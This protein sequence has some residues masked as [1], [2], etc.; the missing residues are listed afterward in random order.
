MKLIIKDDEDRKTVVPL[1]RDE[2]SIGRQEGN[3]IRLT[4]RNV[5]RKH[6]RLLKQNGSLFVEDLGSYNG[7]QVNGVRVEARQSI[8]EGD[9]I[10]IGDYVLE[11]EGAPGVGD[12]DTNPTNGHVEPPSNRTPPLAQPQP[13]ASPSTAPM[14]PAVAPAAPPRKTDANAT[15][16]IRLS[17]LGRPADDEVRDLASHEAARIVC[18]AG[19]LRGIEHKLKRSVVKFGRTDDGNDIVIDHQS[20]SRTHGR[21]QLEADGWKLYDNKS[22]NG[23]RVNGDEYGMSPVKPGDTIEL[24]HVKFRFVGPG[25]QFTLPR[26][27]APSAQSSSAA[28][29]HLEAPV[30]KSKAPLFIGIGAVV[31]LAVVAVV[32]FAIP[33]GPQGPDPKENCLKAQAA[34]GTKDWAGAITALGMAQSLN[35]QC[36]F[37]V[38]TLLQQAQSEKKVKELIEEAQLYIEEGKFRQSLKILESVPGDSSYSAEAKLKAVEVRRDGV[39]KYTDEAQRALDKGRGDEAGQFVDDI[40]ALDRENP[41][42]QLLRG[43]LVALKAKQAAPPPP[44]KKPIEERNKA[45]EA[46]I[47]DGLK[48]VRAGDTDGGIAALKSALDEDPDATMKAKAARNLGISFARKGDTASAVKFYKL[49]LQFDPNSAEAPKIRQ[50]IAQHGG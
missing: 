46:L 38:G 23:I 9:S 33:K 35:V 42:V 10:A 3:T 21:F 47:A 13:R 11:I 20:I 8:S 5:S 6:A 19:N 31:V 26:E 17:D 43:K 12:G 37:E 2:I 39:K 50:I 34:M 24:G 18:I 49:Y 32:V 22:A 30:A 41:V 45:A 28:P 4:D 7:V 27:A 1:V 25:E 29:E 48:K 44:V 16:V 15:A 14:A 36:P 40:E